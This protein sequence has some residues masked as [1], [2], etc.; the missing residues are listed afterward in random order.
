MF[1]ER[2]CTYFRQYRLN[3]THYP[4]IVFPF[5]DKIDMTNSYLIR[6]HLLI[7]HPSNN[8]ALKIWHLL[9]YLAPINIIFNILANV[10]QN[11]FIQISPDL[12]SMQVY[13]SVR[14]WQITKLVITS[15]FPSYRTPPKAAMHSESRKKGPGYY[16]RRIASYTYL[17]ILASGLNWACQAEQL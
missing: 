14:F 11:G 16:L 3:N 10:L 5:T 4:M 8:L 9:I 7:R 2:I 12:A 6:D 1:S 15:T 13:K 17:C